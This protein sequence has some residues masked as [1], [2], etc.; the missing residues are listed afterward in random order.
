[1][2]TVI[3]IIIITGFSAVA[4]MTHTPAFTYALVVAVFDVGA[5]IIAGVLTGVR[6]YLC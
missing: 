6:R 1:M 4:V 2:T 5:I 3:I